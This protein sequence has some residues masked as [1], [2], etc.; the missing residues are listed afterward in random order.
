MNLSRRHFIGG[1]GAAGASLALPGCCCCG[2]APKAKVALQLY[3]IRHYIGGLKDKEGKVLRPGVGLAQTLK[4]VAAIGYKGVEFAGYYG[5]DAKTLK[6]MLDDAGLVAC[7]THVHKEAFSPEKLKETCE[8]NLAYG[9]NLLIS[10][11]GGNTPQGFNWGNPGSAQF[12]DFFK[13]LTEYYAKAAEAAEK[14][15]CRVGLHNHQWEFQ[16]RMADGRT[17]WDYFFSNTPKSV[18]M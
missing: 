11:G 3:S 15:G 7:G 13:E 8:Y 14:Y 16:Y 17:M 5:N 9:N 1:L 12:D 10:P 6:A 18:V 2:G 4:D